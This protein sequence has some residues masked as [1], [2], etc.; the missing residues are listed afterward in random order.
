MKKDVFTSIV[1]L[2][3]RSLLFCANPNMIFQALRQ[4]VAYA[5]YLN[6]QT[7][8]L[9]PPRHRSQVASYA[10]AINECLKST[11]YMN[12]SIRL[13]IYDPAVFQPKETP[14]IPPSATSASST[15]SAPSTPKIV[16]PRISTSKSLKAARAPEGEINATWEMWDII[17]T[18]CDYNTRLTLSMQILYVLETVPDELNASARSHPAITF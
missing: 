4:E 8:I 3:S 13:P 16:T 11:T 9:P 5:S 18:L 1:E 14:P 2:S 6:V 15:P 12:F 17:R 7:V 10:R